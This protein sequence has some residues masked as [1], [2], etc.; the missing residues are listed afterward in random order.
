M[1]PLVVGELTLTHFKNYASAV[2]SFGPGFNVI[3]GLNGMGKTNLLDAVYYL[4]TG[5]SHFSSFDQK[6]V[7]WNAPFFRL[8]GQVKRGDKVH[9]AVIKVKPGSIKELSIDGAIVPRISQHIGFFPVVVSAPGDIE[10]ITGGSVVRRRYFDHLLCQVDPDYLRALMTYNQV[11]QQRNA[12][13]RQRYDDISRITASYDQQITGPATL[14]FEKRKW[15]AS[16]IEG[17]VAETYAILAERREPVA[18][19]YT[20]E[21]FEYP[22]EV[23]ADRNREAD[24]NQMRTLSGIHRDDFDLLV[25]EKPARDFGSQGQIKSLIFALHL[26]KHRLLAQQTGFTP[27]LILDDIFDKLDERRLQQLM[28]MLRSEAFGQ[29]FIS[30]TDSQRVTA[31]LPPEDVCCIQIGE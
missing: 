9:K 18:I 11:L 10:L 2:F 4:C 31:Y 27:L 21:L 25:K 20:S 5:K 23:L 16:Q 13:L 6:V 1:K 15:L 3:A 26:A 24:I 19:H 14:I 12:A 30:D 22:Y 29:V 7:Q 17:L 28:T 8:E